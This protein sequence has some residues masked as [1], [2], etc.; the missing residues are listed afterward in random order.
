MRTQYRHTI[1]RVR[2][3]VIR[4]LWAIV[5][6]LVVC[7]LIPAQARAQDSA[8]IQAVVSPSFPDAYYGW[9]T[10]VTRLTLLAPEPGELLYAWDS[11]LGSWHTYAGPLWA[12]E[13]KRI[14]HVAFVPSDGD[15]IERTSL[16]VKTD[17]DAPSRAVAPAA[18]IAP[19]TGST[20]L[21]KATVTLRPWAGT[22]ITRL[23]GRD[24]Y[25]TSALISERNF[26]VADTVI[27]AT[28]ATFAD[29]LSASGLAGCVEGPVL[30]TQPNAL[31]AT[32]A[33]EIDRLGA[34]KAIIVGGTRAVSGAVATQLA[35]SGLIVERLGG[36]DRFATAALIGR[37]ALGFG[38]SGGRVFV[39]RGDDFADALSLGPLAYVSKAP[40][41]LVLPTSVPP[42]TRSFLSAN[43]FS[44]G[45]IA[46]GTVAVSEGVAA[47][48][49]GYV[50][51]L[52]RLAGSTRYATAGAVAAWGVESELVSYETVGMATGTNFADALCGGVAAGARG[53]AILLTQPGSLP[54]ATGVTIGINLGDMRNIQIYGGERAVFPGVVDQISALLL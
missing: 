8:S 10:N 35:G 29:A 1:T 17:F 16:V 20:R 50:P 6:A 43:R 7:T 21:V 53:G 26:P 42:A 28:G 36:A 33:R 45:C 30:L 37:K 25:E 39:A 23:G 18:P 40:L 46:G 13:G 11:S 54:S 47:Q 34:S 4:A 19:P 48:L 14:L 49:R 32:I 38:Q 44:S 2:T 31:P 15:E 3:L 52:S 22:K 9:S 51:G 12:P 41:V 27:I 24:R 5:I